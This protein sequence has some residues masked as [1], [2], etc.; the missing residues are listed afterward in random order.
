M[1][2]IGDGKT[3]LDSMGGKAHKP[4]GAYPCHNLGGN[5]VTFTKWNLKC[6]SEIL[7]NYSIFTKI[8]CGLKIY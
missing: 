4:V 1:R 2:N 5:Q 8:I 7:K 3:C 6:R